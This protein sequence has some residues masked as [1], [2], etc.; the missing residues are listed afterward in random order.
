ML[1]MLKDPAKRAEWV[2]GQPMAACPKCG[3]Y[4]MKPQMPIAMETTGDETA[5]QLVG[6]WAR[7][8]KAGATPLQ[9]PAYYACWD[10]FHK[11]PAVDCTGRTSEDCRAD[12]V[13]NA[14]MKRLWN[15]QTPN[16]EL[17]GAGKSAAGQATTLHRRPVECRVGR[18]AKRVATADRKGKLATGREPR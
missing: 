14:E 12:R 6:K 16:V 18:L 1:N 7:A 2:Y 5:P 15:A 9:G 4:N 11:G 8:T 13:L 10:C 3:S 17:T